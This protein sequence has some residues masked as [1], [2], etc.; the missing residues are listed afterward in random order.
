MKTYH[1]DTPR[2]GS[3]KR[4]QDVHSRAQ[5]LCQSF[6]AT[7]KFV[8]FSDLVLEESEDSG[9]RATGLQLGGKGMCEKVG[10]CL[11]LIGLQGSPEHGLE[12]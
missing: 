7:V 1:T 6:I 4:A 5:P 11:P 12:A 3:R 10:L 2:D 9:S 8:K